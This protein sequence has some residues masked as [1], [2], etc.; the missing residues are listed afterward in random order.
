MDLKLENMSRKIQMVKAQ[1]TILSE[2]TNKAKDQCETLG[3]T[4]SMLCSEVSCMALC[5][6]RDMPPC[7]CTHCY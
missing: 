3:S 2:Q 1:N 7:P 4:L 6:S 5:F